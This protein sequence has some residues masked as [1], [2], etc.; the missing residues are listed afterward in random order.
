MRPVWWNE[1]KEHLVQV[2]QAFIPLIESSLSVPWRDPG[3]PFASLARAVIGQQI[4]V[5]AAASVW[6]KIL[7]VTQSSLAS[8]PSPL[9][10]RTLTPDSLR[11]CGVS[12]RK[13]EYLH[14]LADHFLNPLFSESQFLDREDEAILSELTAIR[15]IGRWTGEMF[16]MF[17]LHRPD[18]LPLGDLGLRTA[19]GKLFGSGSALS[20]QEVKILAQP[21]RPYAT[22]ATWLL[23]QSLNMQANN[24]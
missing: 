6:K 14:A 5:A 2:E 23:W 18:V 20:P 9:A 8:P 1:A 21:W 12:Q 24:V 4:S 11:E 7:A 17:H 13:A 19:A 3:Q 15:G 22:A 16:L 10:I